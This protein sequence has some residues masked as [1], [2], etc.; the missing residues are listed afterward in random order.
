[1]KA[2]DRRSGSKMLLRGAGAGAAH[3]TRLE[4]DSGLVEALRRDASD[5]AEMLVAR[6]GNCVLR[7]ARRITRSEEDAEEVAQDALWTVVRKINSF[8][9]EALP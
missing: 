3:T 4:P 9:G 5:A 2:N 1:M 7:L 6:Y 8:T